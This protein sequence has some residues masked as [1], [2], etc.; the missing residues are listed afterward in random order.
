MD[1]FWGAVF[2]FLVDKSIWFWTAGA[3]V[4][5]RLMYHSKQVQQGRRRFFSKDLVMEMF[6]ALGMGFMAHGLCQYLSVHGDVEIAIVILVS[7]LGPNGVNA[8]F[9][10]WLKKQQQKEKTNEE[11]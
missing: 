4:L 1:E 9:D 7:Y 2:D 8:V 11:G 5:G 6:I 3:G 10:T